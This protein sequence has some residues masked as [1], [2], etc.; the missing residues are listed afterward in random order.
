MVKSEAR[1]TPT[2]AQLGLAVSATLAACSPEA[3]APAASAAATPDKVRAA[4]MRCASDE[5]PHL[6]GLANAGAVDADYAAS[7]RAG[8]K[9]CKAAV[10]ELRT[11][12]APLECIQ[13]AE[14]FETLH[15]SLSSAL[16][17]QPKPNWE[18]GVTVTMA[19][20]GSCA[21]AAHF[22]SAGKSPDQDAATAASAAAAAA[23]AAAADAIA[24]AE[25][26]QRNAR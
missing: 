5:M 23:Q 4:V 8:A 25:E 20:A 21:D 15:W 1:R 10:A 3:S 16:S 26:V 12:K 14:Q 24:A 2:F 6:I 7:A 17:G 19:L 22:P 13:T 9:R 11:M 18:S